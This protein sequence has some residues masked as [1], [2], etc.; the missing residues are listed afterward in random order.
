MR[1][2]NKLKA[3]LGSD[4]N[5]AVAF[6]LSRQGVLYWKKYGIPWK[7]AEQVEKVTKGKITIMDVIKG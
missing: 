5:I 2:F 7:R 1:T 3:L 6:D 4:D